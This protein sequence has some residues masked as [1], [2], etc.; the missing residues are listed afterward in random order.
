MNDATDTQQSRQGATT[1]SQQERQ[2][3]TPPQVARLNQRTGQPGNTQPRTQ[4]AGMIPTATGAATRQ[5]RHRTPSSHN[6]APWCAL[7]LSVMCQPVEWV[8]LPADS[9]TGCESLSRGC[10]CRW[11]I[12]G[13][14]PDGGT[15]RPAQRRLW[16]DC[17]VNCQSFNIVWRCVMCGEGENLPNWK[18]LQPYTCIMT[19]KRGYRG[20]NK[21]KFCCVSVAVYFCCACIKLK[22]N[23]L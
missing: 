22:S 20:I 12:C 6:I 2:Q 23:Y 17:D 3:L 16:V 15:D 11:P 13:F 10:G 21:V 14:V 19:P 1:A 18:K 7:R 4:A 5:S 9:P 8:E